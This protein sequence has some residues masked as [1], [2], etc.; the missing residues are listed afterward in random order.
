MP[1]G[2]LSPYRVV[3]LAGPEG[4]LAGML[5]AGFGAEVIRL[6]PPGGDPLRALP[7]VTPAGVG[8]WWPAWNRGK[9]S[10]TVD[11]ATPAGRAE[12]T[13]LIESADVLLESGSPGWLGL[14]GIDLEAILAHRPDL[15][16]VA[17]SPF[18]LTGPFAGYLAGDLVAQAA[19][20]HLYLDGPPEQPLRI[21]VDIT[22]AQAG[23]QAALAAAFALAA[24]QRWGIGQTVDLS[25]QEAI[26]TTLDWYTQ[27]WDVDRVTRVR[28]G[29]GRDFGDG[30]LLQVLF[31]CKDGYVSNTTYFDLM[32]PD[33][34]GAV[35]LFRWAG[36]DVPPDLA[37]GLVDWAPPEPE[38]EAA[39]AALCRELAA[40]C[41]KLELTAACQERRILTGEVFTPAELLD[42][43]HLRARDFWQTIDIPGAG[44][45]RFPGPPFRL[46][47]TPWVTPAR[48][49]APGEDDSAVRH[50]REPALAPKPRPVD[51]GIFSGLRIADFSWVGVGPLT[52]KYFADQ[53]A[54]VIRVESALRPDVLRYAGPFP[55]GVAH[56]DASPYYA[57]FNSSKLGCTLNLQH[58][59]AARLAWAL[60]ERSDVVAESFRNGVMER[61]GLTYDEARRRNPGIIW[62]RM[63][64]FG[65]SGPWSDRA[66]YGHTLQG[67]VG[68]TEL[69]GYAD[70]E[71]LGSSTAFTD[72]FNPHLA[73]FAL[74]VA[75]EHRRQTGEGQLIEV[76]QIETGIYAL[77]PA[78]LAAQ[79][80]AGGVHRDGNR[81]PTAVPHN[82][83]RCEGADRWLAIACL[84]DAQWTALVEA[85]GAPS[86][87]TVA[88][89]ATADGRRRSEAEID[90]RL[91]DWTA[92]YPAEEL[93][94]FL[95]ARGVPAA[96]VATIEDLHKDAQ[97][98]H[99][100]HFRPLGSTTPP[101]SASAQHPSRFPAPRRSSAS[102]T[103]TC[104]RPSPVS[105]TS[106]LPRSWPR[107]RSSS[108]CD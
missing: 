33:T 58:P 59:Q 88:E 69:H 27:G 54:E 74:A 28:M 48:L 37:K 61:M 16:H 51:G 41:G 49:A 36:L 30:A 32:S 85:M 81:H 73:A 22:H 96:L 6:E 7:P 75:L 46:G 43:E 53:G 40:R 107:G 83:Y 12:A 4:W 47:A 10:V 80:G 18:G 20:G 19:G 79:L 2:P 72:F 1:G 64:M 70:G 45:A 103:T 105:T 90:A 26:A 65:T 55:G 71:P 52:T 38:V 86:W 31:R 42:L 76:A 39:M 25:L 66:G 11:L 56:I 104:G 34:A 101:R 91:G 50:E 94:H 78:I 102:T 84:T 67:T 8:L 95:Q 97:L 14:L 57:N 106:S 100:W 29:Q 77:G 62:L 93:M 92:R 23:V 89:F 68:I 17:I 99:R 9:R 5:L 87:A 108:D 98:A 15:V 63:P 13:A 24:R 3:D 60:I 44:P 82:T 21:S 35:D